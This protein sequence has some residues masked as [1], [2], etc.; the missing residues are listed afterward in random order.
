[1]S[2]PYTFVSSG[3][4]KGAVLNFAKSIKS[5]PSRALTHVHQTSHRSGVS[6]SQQ[7]LGFVD[8]SIRRDICAWFFYTGKDVFMFIFGLARCHLYDCL[9]RAPRI[10]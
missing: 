8:R 5:T 10:G 3:C 9:R 6:E 1:M 4:S 2:L 7:R